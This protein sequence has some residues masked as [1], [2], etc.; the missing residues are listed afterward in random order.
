VNPAANH[1][2]QRGRRL[3]ILIADDEQD[4]VTTLAAILEDEG[5][6]VHTVTNGAL[7]MH[8]I[9]RFKPD[10]CI[11][12]IEMP[13]QSGYSLAREISE[14]KMPERPL[15]IAI[16]GKWKTQTDKFLAKSVGFDHFFVKPAEPAEVIAA[17]EPLRGPTRAA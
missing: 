4:T 9:E 10:V 13:G 5:H 11:F 12:D 3:G 1:A 14:A 7:V 8:A 6:V 15:L 16:S 17:L 2:P